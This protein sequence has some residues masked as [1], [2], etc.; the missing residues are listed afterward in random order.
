MTVST[1][2]VFVAAGMLFVALAIVFAYRGYLVRSSERRM[3]R[4][5]EKVG[6]DPDIVADGDIP[7]IMHDVRARCR[8]CSSESVCERWLDGEEAGENDFCPNHRVFEILQKYS[9]Q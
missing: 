5:L 8:T 9:A 2:Q 1:D 6:L 3:S 7:T 4:M